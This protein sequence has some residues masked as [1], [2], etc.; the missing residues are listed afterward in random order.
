M[1]PRHDRNGTDRIRGRTIDYL[2]TD[3]EVR[4]RIPRFIHHAINASRLE[5]NAGLLTEHFFIV[6]EL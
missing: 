4:D 1:W 3:S 5:K 2:G 6:A